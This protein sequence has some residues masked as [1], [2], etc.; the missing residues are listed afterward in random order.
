MHFAAVTSR[1]RLPCGLGNEC[2]NYFTATAE[3]SAQLLSSV[4]ENEGKE[5]RTKRSSFARANAGLRRHI[6]V[7][8]VFNS[9]QSTV[10]VQKG[11]GPRRREG[12]GD[13]DRDRER[14]QQKEAS[15]R[16]RLD[17]QYPC[18]P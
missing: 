13:R 7:S 5:T 2:H 9:R 8:E 12:E 10:P 3:V 15:R 18:F 6:S 1:F 11:I 16:T 17:E 14:E 4:R